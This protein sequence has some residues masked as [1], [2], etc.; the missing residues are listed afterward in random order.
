MAPETVPDRDLPLVW[1][2]RW[3]QVIEDGLLRGCLAPLHLPI[4]PERNSST[5][6][7][8][9]GMLFLF[10]SFAVWSLWFLLPRLND[11]VV[12]TP[13]GVFLLVSS[14]VPSLCLLYMVFVPRAASIAHF[15]VF[16]AHVRFVVLSICLPPEVVEQIR[17]ENTFLAQFSLEDLLGSGWE[18]HILCGRG[19][20][21]EVVC[22]VLDSLLAHVRPVKGHEDCLY[23]LFIKDFLVLLD[24]CL[25]LIYFAG[26]AA[27][28]FTVLCSS[29]CLNQEQPPLTWWVLVSLNVAL[30]FV[31]VVQW[32]HLTYVREWYIG[33]QT[34][35]SDRVQFLY[36]QVLHT[37]PS[38]EIPRSLPPHLEKLLA[39]VADKGVDRL[40][41][42]LEELQVMQQS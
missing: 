12:T 29:Y 26:A 18:D 37:R 42:L 41:S 16:A 7:V 30:L 20:E 21:L 1:N 11:A 34:K 5:S 15:K 28:V 27:I 14:S 19:T 39:D 10:V 8:L 22:R 13:F 17:F 33:Y 4:A 24:R 9:S 23:E 32:Y 6:N 3:T 31:V 25:A 40:N 2:L 36:P 38:A 35:S